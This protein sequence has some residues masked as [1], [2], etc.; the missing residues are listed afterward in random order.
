MSAGLPPGTAIYTGDETGGPAQITAIDWGPDCFERQEL[1]APA[2]AAPFRDSPEP[3]WIAMIGI[4]DVAAV[5]AVGEVFDLHPLV[6]EDICNVQQRPKLDDLGHVLFLTLKLARFD[7]QRQRIDQEPLS[8]ILGERFLLSFE[9]I[10]LELFNPLDAALEKGGTRLRD[11][12]P[13]Y[14][15]YRLM[16]V[17]VDQYI[18]TLEQVGDAVEHLEDTLVRCPEEESLGR[19]HDLRRDLMEMR[20]SIWPLRDVIRRLQRDGD[21]LICKETQLYFGDLY[22]HLSQALDVLETELSLAAGLYDVYLNAVSNRTNQV[23]HVLTVFSTIF[24]PL[25]FIT[26]LYGMNF[27]HMPELKTPY[28]YPIAVA[29]MVFVVSIMLVWFRRKRWI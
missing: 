5:A 1:A 19:I 24:L 3:T 15:L 10:D 29:A 28:G 25:T 20:R 17:V 13:D 8:M 22:D 9:E 7:D 16:D 21:A 11:S 12:G 2:D 23:M 18:V 6:I 4:H 27:E 26:G 14:L